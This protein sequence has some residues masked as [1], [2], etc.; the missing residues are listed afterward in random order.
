M[1]F[2]VNQLLKGWTDGLDGTVQVVTFFFFSFFVSENSLSVQ[3]LTEWRSDFISWP[4]RNRKT[5]N[6]ASR[7][8]RL[9]SARHGTAVQVSVSVLFLSPD[10]LRRKLSQLSDSI[11]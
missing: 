3:L 10:R 8:A 6:F 1:A 2:E 5:D 9:G 4:K 7:T 11:S